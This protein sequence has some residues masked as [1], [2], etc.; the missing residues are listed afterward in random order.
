MKNSRKVPCSS[1]QF[2]TPY[3]K[4]QMPTSVLYSGQD[5]QRKVRMGAVKKIVDEF[6][7]KLLDEVVVSF[8][9]N[10]YNVV[11][12]QHRI[13]ALK[14]MNGGSDCM[15]SCKVISGLTYEQEAAL[16]ER[17]DA[18]KKRLNVS[19]ST[20]AK[21]EAGNDQSLLNIKQA[22]E[23][24]GITWSFSSLG[25]GGG[26]NKISATRA[27]LNAYSLLGYMSFSQMIRM[28]KETWNGKEESLNMYMVSGMSLFVKTYADDIDEKYFVKKLSNVN[29][30][31]IIAEGKTDISTREMALKYARVIWSKYNYKSS[32][33]ALGYK[34]KG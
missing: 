24:N 18:S 3:E 31:E 16:Y 33:N 11:D 8:R 26:T 34:F 15:I 4:R 6:D 25:G 29:P 27:L 32:K 7:P 13:T 14:I 19:D 9:D 22:L 10:R 17:L 5:Y 1:Y 30:K 12:G 20:R 2:T 28:I 23:M 21:V